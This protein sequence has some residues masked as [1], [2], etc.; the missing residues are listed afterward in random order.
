[1]PADAFYVFGDEAHGVHRILITGKLGARR[2]IRTH[3]TQILSLLTA[4]GWSIRASRDFLTNHQLSSTPTQSDNHPA[5][6]KFL[7][8]TFLAL[9]IHNLV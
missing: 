6:Y 1:M 4:S 7:C 3:T 5:T 8:N 9:T 2:G